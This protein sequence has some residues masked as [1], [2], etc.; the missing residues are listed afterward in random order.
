MI[1]LINLVLAVAVSKGDR[2]ASRFL[3]ASAVVVGLLAWVPLAR[4]LW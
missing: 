1:T 4:F 3:L 2:F